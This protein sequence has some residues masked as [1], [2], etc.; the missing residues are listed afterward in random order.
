MRG[1]PH[2]QQA[3][4]SSELNADWPDL[5]CDLQVSES[6]TTMGTVLRNYT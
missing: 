5:V 3:G 2:R 4:E 6:L 1:S